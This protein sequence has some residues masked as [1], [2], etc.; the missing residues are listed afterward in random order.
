LHREGEKG[1]ERGRGVNRYNVTRNGMEESETG[2][3]IWFEDH[4]K[5]IAALKAK[6]AA[7]SGALESIQVRCDIGDK[8]CDW[9]PII[10]DIAYRALTKLAA[11]SALGD[12]K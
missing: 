12:G 1:E 3:Y 9:I 6:L 10:R 4:E 8:R 11:K 7:A 2:W 5:E